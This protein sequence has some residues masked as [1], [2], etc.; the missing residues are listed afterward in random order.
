[1]VSGP[2]QKASASRAAASGQA[3]G[4]RARRG[5]IGDVHDHRVP[6]RTL[7]GGEDL[8]DRRGVECVGAESV[9]GFGGKGHQ[10]AGAQDFGGL[11]QGRVARDVRLESA[12]RRRRRVFIA[13]YSLGSTMPVWF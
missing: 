3:G 12:A 1:M 11:E 5:H 10:A 6:V 9:D 4:E 2:G 8:L 13:A 7:L